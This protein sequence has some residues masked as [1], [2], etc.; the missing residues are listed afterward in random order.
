MN[1]YKAIITQECQDGSYK[2]ALSDYVKGYFRAGRCKGKTQESM[3]DDMLNMFK[4]MYGSHPD[5]YVGVAI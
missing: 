5:V 2:Q 1:E 4:T 3:R